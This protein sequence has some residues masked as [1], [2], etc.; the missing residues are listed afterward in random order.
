M[1]SAFGVTNRIEVVVVKVEQ[2]VKSDKMYI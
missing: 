2:Q 1:F